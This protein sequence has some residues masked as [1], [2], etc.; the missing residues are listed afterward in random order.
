MSSATKAYNIVLLGQNFHIVEL[1]ILLSITLEQILLLKHVELITQL[2][3]EDRREDQ[4]CGLWVVFKVYLYLYIYRVAGASFFVR[5]TIL[6][7]SDTLA[8]LPSHLNLKLQHTGK[9]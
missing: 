6:H 8:L 7:F 1:K 5:P 4:I 3:Y 2:T 9:I